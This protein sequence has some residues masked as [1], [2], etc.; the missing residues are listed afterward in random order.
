MEVVRLLHFFHRDSSSPA[1][2][3]TLPSSPST[4]SSSPPPSKSSSAAAFVHGARPTGT[5]GRAAAAGQMQTLGQL[6][7][8][9]KFNMNLKRGNLSIRICS[10]YF[11]IHLIDEVDYRDCK[12]CD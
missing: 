7:G 2:F 9:Q 10:S 4:S 5:L 1:S 11:S 6:L 3:Y 12:F 8:R